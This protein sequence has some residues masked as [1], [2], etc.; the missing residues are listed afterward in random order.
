MAAF[1]FSLPG[2]LAQGYSISPLDGTLRSDMDSGLARVR[3]RSTARLDRVEAIWRLR[4]AELAAFRA[5][6]S[7]ATGYNLFRGA[8]AMHLSPWVAT[9]ATLTAEAQTAPDGST[10]VSRLSET[11]ETGLHHVGL[12]VSFVAGQAYTMQL[13][14]KAAGRT[15]ALLQMGNGLAFGGVNPGVRVDLSSGAVLAVTGAVTDFGVRDEGGGGWWRAHLTASATA[16][17]S[18][19]IFA[20]LTHNGTTTSYLGVPGL[21]V[22]VWGA[23]IQAGP[24]MPYLPTGAATPAAVD[25][26]VGGAGWF[27]IRLPLGG[28]TPETRLARFV[29]APSYRAHRPGF[30]DVAA[31]LEVR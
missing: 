23:Q 21:G 24:L 29:G 12:N 8:Q 11:A 19:R 18:D 15:Q 13:S 9:R 14:I 31:T 30:W 26:L 3:L 28:A 6:V 4:T 16:T 27:D 20:P 25:G 2:P 22:L 5:W 10:G 17:A 1:P 7:S